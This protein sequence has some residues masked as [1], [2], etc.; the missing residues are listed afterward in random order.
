MLLAPFEML[1][2]ALIFQGKKEKTCQWSHSNLISDMAEGWGGGKTE[3]CDFNVMWG[4][5]KI[6]LRYGQ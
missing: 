1:A 3:L 5:Q 6:L 2:A 4:R